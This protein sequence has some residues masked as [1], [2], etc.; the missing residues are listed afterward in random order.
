MSDLLAADAVSPR[1]EIAARI[2]SLAPVALF[3]VNP[4]LRLQHLGVSPELLVLLVLVAVIVL[5]N[6]DVGCLGLRLS[7]VGGWWH[8]CRLAL[9]IGLILGGLLLLWGAVIYFGHISVTM[10]AIDP[11][12]RLWMFAYMCITAP[13]TEELVF[14]SLLTVAV[15]PTLG[16]RG[17]IIVSGLLFAAAHIIGGNPGLENQVAGFL[18]MWAFLR[19]G[20]IL[21]P[22]AWHS[23]GNLVAFSAQVANWHLMPPTWP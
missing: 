15:R 1:C 4:W 17:T 16:D 22:L 11:E 5:R 3:V 19:S 10:T 8:W 20:T 14:R 12:Q 9:V 23:A 13:L 7:P 6:G 21:V 18:L 2:L